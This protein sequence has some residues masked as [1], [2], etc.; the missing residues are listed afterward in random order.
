MILGECEPLKAI[1]AVSPN[2]VPEPYAWGKYDG[3]DSNTYFLLTEFRG[4]GEQP[5]NP[6]KFTKRLAEMPPSVQA[7]EWPQHQA[8]FG[9]WGSLG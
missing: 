3:P 5:P 4:V 1:H 6:V 7:V 8:L 9:S 2:L